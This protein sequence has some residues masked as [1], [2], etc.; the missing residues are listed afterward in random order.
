MIQLPP[1][2]TVTYAVWVDIKEMSNDIVNWYK[3]IG[4]TVTQDSWYNHR[5][6]KIEREF[7]Q[8]GKAKR[9]HYRQDGT[10]G[11][12]LHFHGDDAS[13]ASMFLLK[14]NDIVENHNMQMVMKQ[15]ERDNA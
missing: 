7:V 2:C 14:F 10:G 5:G 15:Y 12:R 11:I 4:G 13:V 9:C 3:L 6:T 1:G 8:Y